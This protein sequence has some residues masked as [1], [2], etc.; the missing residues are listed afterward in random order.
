MTP[1]EAH[2]SKPSIHLIFRDP[3]AWFDAIDWHTLWPSMFA[4]VP[5]LLILWLFYVGRTPIRKIIDETWYGGLGFP[6]ATGTLALM[7]AG[8][9]DV[10]DLGAIA[11]GNW[12]PTLFWQGP[13][14][15]FLLGLFVGC[16]FFE[17]YRAHSLKS[18]QQTVDSMT[19]EQLSEI[20]RSRELDRIV[21]SK[22]GR[23]HHAVADINRQITLESITDIL[24]PKNQTLLN[25]GALHQCLRDNIPDVDATLS[26]ALYVPTDNNRR[27]SMVLSFDG[28]NWDAHQGSMEMHKDRFTVPPRQ[29]KCL[30]V[31]TA[32]KGGL[33]VINDSSSLTDE[34]KLKFQL[35]YEGHDRTIRSAAAYAYEDWHD[36]VSPVLMA[37]SDHPGVF[38]DPAYPDRLL[39]KDFRFFAVRLFFERDM[40]MLLKRSLTAQP[41]TH[42]STD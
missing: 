9:V 18:L 6:V 21:G 20:V 34:E 31:Y 35:F 25:F 33:H 38:S 10:I 11:N 12:D 15:V 5:T 23:A 26:L 37:H 3:G 4:I 41:T 1:G 7:W 32:Q 29:G 39:K 19:K 30:V 40:D 42:G 27:M 13:V 22:A 2:N 36:G 24:D 17:H 16:L 14:L 28:A 8:L